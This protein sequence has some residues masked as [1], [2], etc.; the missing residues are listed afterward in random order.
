MKNLSDQELL[1]FLSKSKS[2]HLDLNKLMKEYFTEETTPAKTKS[3][4]KS[5]R[6]KQK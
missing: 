2:R 5:N 6:R 1:D 3:L 4:K